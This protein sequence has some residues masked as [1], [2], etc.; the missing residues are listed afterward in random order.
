MS[1]HAGP[2]GMYP[3]Q[4]YMDSQGRGGGSRREGGLILFNLHQPSQ[5]FSPI[6][7]NLLRPP[8][9]FNLLKHSSTLFN[10]LKPSSTFS[11]DRPREIGGGNPPEIVPSPLLLVHER[12]GFHGHQL[13]RDEPRSS[14]YG[15]ARRFG[16]LAPEFTFS[17]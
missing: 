7:L 1:I 11:R 15:F 2:S 4:T 17:I 16:A 8:S 9:I 10:L 3:C 6:F 5:T 12:R 14:E 13:P